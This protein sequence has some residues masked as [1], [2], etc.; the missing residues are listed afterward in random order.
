M[1]YTDVV[2]SIPGISHYYPLTSDAVVDGV[3]SAPIPLN[4]WVLSGHGTSRTWLNNVAK[5]GLSVQV[6]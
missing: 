4:G 6:S 3:G 2:K 5:V 1:S